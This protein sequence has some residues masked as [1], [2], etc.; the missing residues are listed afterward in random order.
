M[1]KTRLEVLLLA[2]RLGDD[3]LAV[4]GDHERVV[5]QGPP[6]LRLPV[7]EGV[8][9]PGEVGRADGHPLAARGVQ[10]GEELLGQGQGL[11]GGL[12]LEPVLPRDQLDA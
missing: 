9:Q 12:D 6:P 7:G 8:D 10:E 2:D 5:K 1:P 3:A 11:L 4:G